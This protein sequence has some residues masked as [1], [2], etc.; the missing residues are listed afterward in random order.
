MAVPASDPSEM[1][2]QLIALGDMGVYGMNRRNP[3]LRRSAQQRRAVDAL[4]GAGLNPRMHVSVRTDLPGTVADGR[5]ISRPLG[6]PRVGGHSV[7]L[8]SADGSGTPPDQTIYNIVQ[9]P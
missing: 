5:W 2:A 1:K 6:K 4:P 8:P 7:C 3:Q 9:Y